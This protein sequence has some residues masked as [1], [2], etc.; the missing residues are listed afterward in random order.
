MSRRERYVQLG[1]RKGKA[2]GHELHIDEKP[3]PVEYPNGHTKFYARCTCGHS[4]NRLGSHKQAILYAF[5][6][7]GSVIAEAEEGSRVN[8]VSKRSG[9]DP[10]LGSEH[11]SSTLAATQSVPGATA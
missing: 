8:G 6:H 2:L 7:L 3:P 5:Y 10:R 1:M 9:Q 4:S 11:Q